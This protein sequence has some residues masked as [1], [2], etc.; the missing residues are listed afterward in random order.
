M[1]EHADPTPMFTA[2]LR[3]FFA[4]PA[5]LELFGAEVIVA[6]EDVPLGWNLLT[7]PPLL[8]VHDDGGPTFGQVKRDVTVR[9]TA[10]ARGVPLAKRVAARADG[11]IHEQRPAGLAALS[12]NGSGFVIARDPETGADLASFTVTTAVATIETV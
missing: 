7:D 6:A 3:A 11:H 5:N 1:R 4:Q 9:V 10:Y 2:A 8:V 12:R